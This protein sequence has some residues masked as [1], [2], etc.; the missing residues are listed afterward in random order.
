MEH[1]PRSLKIVKYGREH[2][3]LYSTHELGYRVTSNDDEP[4]SIQKSGIIGRNKS[5]KEI[6]ASMDGGY[7]FGNT[8]EE[9]WDA[10]KNQ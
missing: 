3:Y 9:I 6:V 4:E 2:N 7:Q 8:A 5:T 1:E 10:I